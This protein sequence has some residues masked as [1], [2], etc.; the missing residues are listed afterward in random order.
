MPRDFSRVLKTKEFKPPVH[1]GNTMPKN[2]FFRSLLKLPILTLIG[3][4]LFVVFLLYSIAAGIVA[5]ATEFGHEFV[6]VFWGLPGW[7][8]I[9]ASAVLI[10]AGIILHWRNKSLGPTRHS[11]KSDEPAPAPEVEPPEPEKAES[12]EE[13]VQEEKTEPAQEAEEPKES[14][15]EQEEKK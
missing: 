5:A 15:T 11:T 14:V 4:A 13:V 12:T 1:G 8:V 2:S 9:I 10:V 3:I 7:L 6:K